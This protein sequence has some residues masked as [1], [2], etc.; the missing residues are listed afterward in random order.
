MPTIL[1]VDDQHCIRE[2]IAEELTDEGYRVETAGDA[3]DAQQ[4]VIFSRPDLVLLDL[5]LGEPDGWE[6]LHDIK[7]QESRLPVIIFTAYDSFKEDPRLSK[8]QGYVI[9]STDFTELKETI[10]R[11]LATTTDRQ[12]DMEVRTYVSQISVAQPF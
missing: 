2:L 10:S 1:V 4:Q 6:V 9:K 3:I 8:A 7:R 11:T 5:F 12:G